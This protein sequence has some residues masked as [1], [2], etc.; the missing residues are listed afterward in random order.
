MKYLY[1]FTTDFFPFTNVFQIEALNH[2]EAIKLWSE[3]ILYKESF[4]N[5]E[6]GLLNKALKKL[7]LSEIGQNVWYFKLD[8]NKETAHIYFILTSREIESYYNTNI[9]PKF[10]HKKL[11]PRDQQIITEDTILTILD[12]NFDF[13]KEMGYIETIE[14][15]EG[16]SYIA[17]TE[18]Y[19][20]FDEVEQL[21]FIQ[22]KLLELGKNISTDLIDMILEYEHEYIESIG[23][24]EDEKVELLDLEFK[25]L[26]N[27]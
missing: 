18:K 23:I 2:I 16:G 15:K 19:D 6:L 20:D 1:T 9:A 7:R 10:I 12:F 26:N 24:F 27:N 3:E 22:L 14:D 21:K 5:I 11:S 25:K 17:Y 4:E 8:L 13:N